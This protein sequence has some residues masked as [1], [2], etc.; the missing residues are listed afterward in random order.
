MSETE[1]KP[2]QAP[3]KVAV[4]EVTQKQ[5]VVAYIGPDIPGAKQYTIFNHGLPDVLKEKMKEHPFFCEFIVPV[6]KLAQASA[7]LAKEGS[8]LNVLFQKATKR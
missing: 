4:K 6:K 7:D 5:E 2:V 3:K 1:K 8:A